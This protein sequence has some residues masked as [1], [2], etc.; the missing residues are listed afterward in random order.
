[1]NTLIHTFDT[2]GFYL[3]SSEMPP[4]A[5]EPNTEVAT[6][7][8][9]PAFDT[10]THRVRRIGDVWTVEP[11]PEPEPEPEQ[12]PLP[13]QFPRYYGNAKLDLFTQAEQL[14]IVTATMA[15]PMVKLM[16]DR[17]LGSAYMTHEDPETEQGL[18]MLVEKGLLTDERKSAIVS[19]MQPQ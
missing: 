6:R 4:F 8:P 16:Y 13:P 1:M 3:G 15:D 10:L 5:A 11:I 2:D 19:L 17:L 7:D 9:L 14:D 12:D 18:A